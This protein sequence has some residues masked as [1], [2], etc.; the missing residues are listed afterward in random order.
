MISVDAYPFLAF[1]DLTCPIED[2]GIGFSGCTALPD[3]K[4]TELGS[5]NQE[6]SPSTPVPCCT[7]KCVPAAITSGVDVSEVPGFHFC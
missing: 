4:E 2:T 7:W 1:S 6:A 5:I 3:S